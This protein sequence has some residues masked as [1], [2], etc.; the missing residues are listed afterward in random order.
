MASQA[1]LSTVVSLF[2]TA[3][4][5]F[6]HVKTINNLPKKKNLYIFYLF[7]FFF[8]AEKAEKYQRSKV[9]SFQ[10]KYQNESLFH[11]DYFMCEDLHFL[12]KEKKATNTVL[13]Q[14]GNDYTISPLEKRILNCAIGLHLLLN[15]SV[16]VR[17]WVYFMF[18]QEEERKKNKLTDSKEFLLPFVSFFFSVFDNSI[19]KKPK[20]LCPFR[21]AVDR[22]I[23]QIWMNFA[24]QTAE[25]KT[26]KFNYWRHRCPINSLLFT[27]ILCI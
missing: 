8:H 12:K 21:F 27:V 24:L 23:W 17:L 13:W 18:E 25:T 16:C 7:T 3:N 1:K 6:E 22:I 11:V 5:N 15:Q 2:W 10:K 9:F 26:I 19:K 14:K 4:W 20:I